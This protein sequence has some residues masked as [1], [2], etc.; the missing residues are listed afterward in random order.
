MSCPASGNAAESAASSAL[1]RAVT[2][3]SEIANAFV[4]GS[5]AWS[6][7]S[8][9]VTGPVTCHFTGSVRRPATS[10]NVRMPP[11][12]SWSRSVSGSRVERGPR[13]YERDAAVDDA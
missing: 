13:P 10:M 3:T 1:T 5:P 8:P 7:P 12:A 9:S 4:A 11:N 2:A 6:S